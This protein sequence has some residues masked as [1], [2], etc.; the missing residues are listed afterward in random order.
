MNLKQAKA[1]KKETKTT[2]SLRM[3]KCITVP[4]NPATGKAKGEI[5]RKIINTITKHS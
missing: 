4:Q 2:S 1:Y 3:T 5:E